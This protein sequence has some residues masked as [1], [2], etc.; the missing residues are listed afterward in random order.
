MT[1]IA[2][3]PQKTIHVIAICG[4]CGKTWSMAKDSYDFWRNYKDKQDICAFCKNI[5]VTYCEGFDISV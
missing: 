3:I 1:D 2:Y 4:E 5:S